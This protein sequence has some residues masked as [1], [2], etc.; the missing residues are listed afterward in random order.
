MKRTPLFISMIGL[1][2]ILFLLPSF[3]QDKASSQ[4]I[5]IEGKNF[6]NASGETMVFRGVNIRDPHNLDAEG[7]W[8]RSHFQEAK[9]WGADVIRLPIHP[10]SWR[11]RG[12]EGYMA[13]IDQA[14]E[15]AREL[16]LYLIL[17]WHSI[18]NL[19]MELFQHGMYITNVEET[20]DFWTPFP[21]DMP[22]NRSY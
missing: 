2:L 21:G 20:I 7:H 19:K 5:R 3:G 16:E 6:V 14:V 11:T 15:W 10:P 4:W 8:T 17:D 9:D 13:L 1:A 22:M 18:G 12:E